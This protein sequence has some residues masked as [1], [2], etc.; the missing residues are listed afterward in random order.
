MP[1]KALSWDETGKRFY[2]TG[3]DHGVLYPLKEGKYKPGVAWSGLTSVNA[4]VPLLRRKRRVLSLVS[5]A[6]RCSVCPIVP[7]KVMTSMVMTRVTNC[8]WF[9]AAP[10]LLLSVLT[11]P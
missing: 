4:M 8:I 2:E 9:T 7:R 5:R 11:R 10:L 3:V 6:V 1:T